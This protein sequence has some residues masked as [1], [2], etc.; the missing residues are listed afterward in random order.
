MDTE[1]MMI[2]MEQDFKEL[3]EQYDGAAENELMFALGAPDAEATKLHT[4]NVVQNREMAKFYRYLATRTL[5]LVE[6]FEED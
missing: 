5:D 2:Q 4:Q 1:L 3:A 6:S